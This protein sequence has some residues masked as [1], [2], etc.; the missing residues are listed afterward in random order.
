MEATQRVVKHR[1]PPMLFTLT[2]RAATPKRVV[3]DL[4]QRAGEEK[5]VA[6][7]LML[8]AMQAVVI[9]TSPQPVVHMLKVTTPKLRQQQLTQ[10]V[11]RLLQ[12]TDPILKWRPEILERVLTPRV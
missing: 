8:R 11:A 4:T 7:A 3:M 1:P 10:K 6:R 5:P 2:Q 9:Q 12:V